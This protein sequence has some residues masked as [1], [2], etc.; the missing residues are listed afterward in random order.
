MAA[1]PQSMY[2]LQPASENPLQQMPRDHEKRPDSAQGT[3]ET[4]HLQI[5][6]GSFRVSYAMARFVYTWQDLSQRNMHVSEA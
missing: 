1:P 5:D 6:T 4:F 2:S 3:T